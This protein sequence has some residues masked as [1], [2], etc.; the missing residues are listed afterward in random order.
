MKKYAFVLMLLAGSLT[1]YISY[2]FS[3]KRENYLEKN[4]NVKENMEL[5]TPSS[6]VNHEK[7]SKEFP[8]E[9]SEITNQK[10]MTAKK[11]IQ[12]NY[13]NLVAKREDNT[14]LNSENTQTMGSKNTQTKSDKNIDNQTF[15]LSYDVY[16]EVEDALKIAVLLQNKSFNEQ[17]ENINTNLKNQLVNKNLSELKIIENQLFNEINQNGYVEKEE[18]I[19]NN[20]KEGYLIGKKGTLII[21]PPNVFVNSKGLI[22]NENILVTLQE[23]YSK[24]EILLSG[25]YTQNVSE[26]FETEG[27]VTIKAYKNGEELNINPSKKIFV[28]LK[29]ENEDNIYHLFN[30]NRDNKWQQIAE[31]DKNLIPLP[32]ETLD[33]HNVFG[34]TYD[35]SYIATKEFSRRYSFY[36]NNATLYK[37]AISGIYLSSIK[38]P[39]YKADELVVQYLKDIKAD[40]NLINEFEKFAEEKLGQVVNFNNVYYNQ[41]LSL[42]EQFE[43]LGNTKSES[44]RLAQY[45]LIRKGVQDWNRNKPKDLSFANRI[46]KVSKLGTFSSM[47]FN[48]SVD[49]YSSV[50]WNN[51]NNI[52]L[53]KCSIFFVIDKNKSITKV[54]VDN[55]KNLYLPSEFNKGSVIIFNKIDNENFMAIYDVSKSNTEI[56]MKQ[57]FDFQK[58][59]INELEN[60]LTD[61]IR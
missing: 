31:Q 16:E 6:L 46:Y 41:E 2:R 29:T 39:L 3:Q 12:E 7:A 53:S 60:K 8:N 19:L 23:Y 37:K 59:N 4:N 17:I 9:K 18:F 33:L 52:D 47:K 45:F 27:L 5:I 42:V 1:T 22:E 28:C 44:E 61:F 30:L 25:F 43:Q 57:K 54:A 24:S 13:E 35:R 55:E 34:N 40:K 10:V 48:K 21:L 49:I 56:N 36:S 11:R 50:Q 58:L 20:H 14:K 15:S 51:L 32:L 38:E 26:I